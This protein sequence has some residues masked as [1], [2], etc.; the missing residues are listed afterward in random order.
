M[1][2]DIRIK[3]QPKQKEAFRLSLVTPV[4]LFGGA[5]GGGKSHLVRAREVFRRLKYPSSRGVIIRKTLPELWD[6]HIYPLLK[7][8]PQIND[9]FKESK[10]TIFWPN[11]SITTFSYLQNKKDVFTYQG[12]EFEDISLDEATQHE[13]ETFSILRSSNRTTLPDIKPS[14]LLTGNPGGVGHQWVKRLFVDKMYRKNEDAN[15]YAFI[16]AN[17]YDNKILLERYPDYLKTLKALPEALRRAYLDGDWNVLAGLMFTEL[18]EDMH[19]CPIKELPVGTTYFGGFDWG[20]GHPFAFVLFALTPEQNMY[21]VGACSGKGKYP[22]QIAEMMKDLVG[23]KKIIAFAGHD[24]WKRGERSTIYDQLQQ[25]LGDSVTLV[26]AF[27]DRKQR[28]SHIHSLLRWQGTDSGT[29]KLRFFTH[30]RPV[31]DAVRQMQI[32]PEDPE[33]V[34][35]VDAD[36]YGYGG[37]DYYDAFGYG[38]MGITNSAAPQ[39][40]VHQFTGQAVLD[41]LMEDTNV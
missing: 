7:E 3:L 13:E 18:D 33:D 12:R 16:Q 32:N 39:P 4:T 19:L 24:I 40:V 8:Y 1:S 21:V 34:I 20:F 26:R 6:N 2:G 15:D 27:L 37:D 31:F 41:E 11:G 17:V 35:K 29:P 22:D 5:K 28:V 9:W 10:K 36:E 30:T 38:V 23:K 25:S 14:M